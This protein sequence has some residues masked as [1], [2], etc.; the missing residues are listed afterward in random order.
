MFF[1]MM[2]YRT[3]FICLLGLLFVSGCSSLSNVDAE[4]NYPKT[5]ED[6]HKERVGSLTGDGGL[7]LFGGSSNDTEN[8]TSGIAVNSYLWRA[9]LDT[10]SFMP[11]ISADP[12]GGFAFH[13]Y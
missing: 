13:C 1:S 10:I 11:L 9:T 7:R 5:R 4:A 3:I 6:Q 2:T 12:F 8:A